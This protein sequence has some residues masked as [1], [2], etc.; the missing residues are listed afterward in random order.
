MKKLPLLL[1]SLLVYTM[2]TAQSEAI[3]KYVGKGVEMH[4][5]GD[6]N[7]ALKEF[8]KAL[9]LDS[10]SDIAN[11]EIANTYFSIKDYPHAIEHADKVIAKNN[12]YLDN[13]Y[14]TKGSSLDMMGKPQEA[15]AIYRKG[16][17]VSPK[18]HLLYYNLAMTCYGQKQ[19]AESIDALKKGLELYSAHASSHLMLG[20]VMQEQGDN[21]KSLLALYNFL[22]LEPMGGRAEK[23]VA[24]IQLDMSAGMRTE[25]SGGKTNLYTTVS[26]TSDDFTS[27]SFSLQLLQASQMTDDSKK[28]KSEAE[29]FMQKTTTFLGLLKTLKKNNSGF[30]WNYYVDFYIDMFKDKDRQEAFVHVIASPLNDNKVTEWIK[31]NK[32]KI[33]KL[34]HWFQSARKI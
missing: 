10:N 16:I 12:R 4:D 15:I 14:V 34:I 23:A 19:F 6:Y 26:D 25:K 28:K 1:V 24:A 27:V 9:A 33:D 22:L 29:M 5:K 11:T 30:W 18:H 13:V 20:F 21:I 31:N 32:P 2:L 7:G 17:K 3:L 8:K